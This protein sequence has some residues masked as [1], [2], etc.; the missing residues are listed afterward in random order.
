MDVNVIG[1]D[2]REVDFQVKLVE[3]NP[4]SNR[5]LLHSISALP[6]IPGDWVAEATRATIGKLILRQSLLDANHEKQTVVVVEHDSGTWME[7]S[8]S[9]STDASLLILCIHLPKK[10]DKITLHIDDMHAACI[11]SAPVVKNGQGGLSNK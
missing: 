2:G 9:S 6:L 1:P 3:I 4:G 10:M 5:L 11:L 8:L 7:A